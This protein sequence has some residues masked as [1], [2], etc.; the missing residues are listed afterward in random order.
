MATVYSFDADFH[1]EDD[2]AGEELQLDDQPEVDDVGDQ[3][4]KCMQPTLRSRFKE[5]KGGGNRFKRRARANHIMSSTSTN[6]NH[7]Y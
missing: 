5:Y 1:G 3:I 2:G 4:V 7:I 6:Y